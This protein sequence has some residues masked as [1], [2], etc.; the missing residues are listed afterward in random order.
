MATYLPTYEAHMESHNKGLLRKRYNVAAE[1][2]KSRSVH[3]FD[4]AILEIG[5]SRPLW[6][7]VVLLIFLPTWAYG[8]TSALASDKGMG[9]KWESSFMSGTESWLMHILVFLVFTL[10]L[11]NEQG[12]LENS[13]T[14]AHKLHHDVNFNIAM[15]KAFAT[16]R[17][18]NV[19]QTNPAEFQWPDMLQQNP[20]QFLDLNALFHYRHPV[21]RSNLFFGILGAYDHASSA[22][23]WRSIG[24]F[25]TLRHWALAF[26]AIFYLVFAPVL[27]F[28][29][30][31]RIGDLVF[32]YIIKV[33]LPTIA[34]AIILNYAN[35]YT[36]QDVEKEARDYITT[37]TKTDNFSAEVIPP[38]EPKKDK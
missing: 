28:G 29:Q 33:S 20:S 12:T 3:W 30:S 24:P 2:E 37:A 21:A 6:T 17:L 5:G 27:E 25:R 15:L 14:P 18:P 8:I 9:R 34:V 23:S 22:V 38:D 36:L 7:V 16:K 26:Y 13:L 11:G 1:V 19:I 4:R 10:V 35:V 32:I 31:S